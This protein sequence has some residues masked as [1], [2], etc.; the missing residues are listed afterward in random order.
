MISIEP[1]LNSIAD[2]ERTIDHLDRVLH[3]LPE[4]VWDAAFYHW[5][6]QMD[7]RFEIEGPRWKPLSQRTVNERMMLDYG[8]EHMILQREGFLRRSLTELTGPVAGFVKQEGGAIRPIQTGN[9]LAE[10][11]N[12]NDVEYRFGTQDERFIELNFDRPMLPNP[13]EQKV[14]ADNIGKT[15]GPIIKVMA[16]PNV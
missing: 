11:R 16:N 15:L 6:E 13:Y 5:S 10:I 12:G 14:L 9:V 4:L 2:I 7:E 3:E 1:D 8:G